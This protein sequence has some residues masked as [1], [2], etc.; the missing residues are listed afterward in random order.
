MFGLD[1]DLLDKDSILGAAITAAVVIGL[2][3]VTQ[4][5]SLTI[6]GFGAGTTALMAGAV[7]F[8]LSYGTSVLS[9]ALSPDMTTS[10]GDRGY[11]LTVKGSTLP[12]QIIYGKTKV[13]GGIMYQGTTANN[14]YLHN[15]IAFS[16]HEIEDFESVYFNDEKLTLSG[17]GV[18]VVSPDKYVNKVKIIKRL[19]TA[20]QEAV[21]TSDLTTTNSFTTDATG[22]KEGTQ[23]TII[24]LGNTDFT[25]VGA[26]SNT[27]GTSFVAT[28]NGAELAQGRGLVT[29]TQTSSIPVPA[30]WTSNHRL[31]ATAYLYIVLQF[32]SDVFP[33]G[34]PEI[35][36]VVKGKK[37]Y[38]PRTSTTAWSD[39]P[40]LCLR[41]YITSGKGGDNTTIYNYGIG[42][43]IGNVDDDLVT[44]AA[45]VCDYLDYPT[46]SGDTRFS[47]NGAFTTN[48]T[49][50]D[51]I[52]NLSTA[53][54]G[55]LWYAQ[56][57]WRMKP[58]YYTN[59]VLHLDEDDLRS[60]LSIVTRHSR[61]DNFNIVKGTF[62]GEESGWQISDFPQVPKFNSSSY[63]A[64]LEVDN[65]QESVIDLQLPFTDNSVQARR[66]ARITLERNRQQL[67]VQA[68]FGLRALQVQ[69]GDII[70]LTNT[71]LG[72]SNK[73]FEV[74]TWSFGS[75][76]DYDIQ[77]TMSLVEISESVFD[78]I[79]DGVV[80]E[81]DNT[82]L[83]S[84]F[85][86]PP[87]GLGASQD[88][89]VINEHLTNVLV[90]D[91]TADS[92][93]RIDYVEIEYKLSTDSNYTTLATGDLG[94][95][96]II[97]IEVP[98]I[99]PTT[100]QAS[101]T[102]T[103]D[104]RARAIN[105]FGI[106]GEFEYIS[107]T[108]EPDTT[109]PNNVS[110]LTKEISGGT[111]FFKWTASDSLDLS[112]YRLHYQ[113]STTA[114][115]ITNGQVLIDKI[116]RPATSITYP[117]LRGTFFL[118]TWDKSGNKADNPVSVVVQPSELPSLDEIE[119]TADTYEGVKS[120]TVGTVTT[121]NITS[122]N[123]VVGKAYVIRSLGT[124]DWNAVAGTT[125][126]T[127][128]VGE[129]IYVKAQSAGTGYG[130][131]KSLRLSSFT[132]PTTGT[133]DAEADGYNSLEYIDT[134]NARTVRV[135]YEIEFERHHS[136][137]QSS[138]GF[139]EV[140]WD[141]IPQVWSTWPDNWDTWTLEQAEFNDYSV[142][143]QVDASNT[144]T[145]SNNWVTATGEA[146][147]RYFRFR[148]VLKNENANVSPQVLSFKGIVE[149]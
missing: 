127:Y 94:R 141:D 95:F 118:Q 41:D 76:S 55:L 47:L 60:G 45:N 109:K 78:D 129:S 90:I 48:T 53:M 104:I 122:S 82:T 4:G 146:V 32:D 61:R 43:D 89:R 6:M 81:N 96:E 19:G 132:S 71:R 123:M 75:S 108:V 30:E 84:A 126:V 119:D 8:G 111:I 93:E 116:A 27:V 52:Q 26:P 120:N 74:T 112:F 35:S 135:S 114:S 20:T 69:V 24:F 46:L 15:V 92:P 99:D 17:N 149:Y 56:G 70:T 66:I 54:G 21:T 16:G 14:K 98:D 125:G 79:D 134:G 18:D 147:G 137:V 36:A 107:P 121:S 136:Q 23:Y 91:V 5:A 110:N 31:L 67:A 37:V 44:I 62:R 115:S 13:S 29:F 142:E 138:T 144:T 83:P 87:I 103:Y 130:W 9:K 12:H 80:Y 113:S 100:G 40:A 72:F 58:A 68:S 88:Y 101:G 49:P 65:G 145:F 10:G 143:V 86:V 148:L 2:A 11:Q 63:N 128:S 3:V 133:Y 33:N 34:V 124:T 22:I 139:T 7:T 105:A 38:D 51:A 131:R 25:L 59:P 117:A 73:E 50:Y 77:I 64:F 28:Q 85:D 57:K 39:N 1:I 140:Y 106:K 97:D 102:V 42:E